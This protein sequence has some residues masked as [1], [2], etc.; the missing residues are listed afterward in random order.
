MGIKHAMSK[1]HQLKQHAQTKSFEAAHLNQ[2]ILK[3]TKN[4]T[5]SFSM[6]KQK[7]IHLTLRSSEL[8][9][10]N[11]MHLLNECQI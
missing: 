3:K 8:L 10:L 11:K 4:R 2:I 7:V 9:L 1:K 6:R 5:M